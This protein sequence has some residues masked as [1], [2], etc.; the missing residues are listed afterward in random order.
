[1]QKKQFQILQQFFLQNL[2]HCC[3][4]RFQFQLKGASL[5]EG[6]AGHDMSKQ[7]VLQF[8][9]GN[10]LTTKNCTKAKKKIKLRRKSSISLDHPTRALAKKN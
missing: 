1:M 7:C 3:F 8:I 6:G 2:P 5:E 9:R 10:L 4:Q